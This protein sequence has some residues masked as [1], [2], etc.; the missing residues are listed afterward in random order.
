MLN[1]ISKALQEQDDSVLYEK[2]EAKPDA[3]TGNFLV[4]SEPPRIHMEGYDRL[5]VNLFLRDKGV[6][7]TDGV[8]R[9]NEI[10]KYLEKSPGAD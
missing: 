4:Y 6:R 2:R 10:G 9:D 8:F 5:L 1:C 7:H 3:M